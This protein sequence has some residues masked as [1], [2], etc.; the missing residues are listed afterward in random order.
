MHQRD[1]GQVR[2][3]AVFGHAN[4]GK[5]M[6]CDAML[7][8]AGATNRLGNIESGTTVSDYTDE[9]QARQISIAT[10]ALRCAWKDTTLFVLD[11]PGAADF[12]GEVLSA[13]RVCDCAVV[14]VDG[15]SGIEVQ[16]TKIWRLLEAA[17]MPTVVFVNKLDKE[18]S[19]F[20]EVVASLREAFGASPST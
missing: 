6:L 11:T 18:N 4:C 1:V 19:D 20:G 12:F 16:T 3:L 2:I 17:A 10:T 15:V 9:E 8:A 7:H 13:A 5:T 14:V